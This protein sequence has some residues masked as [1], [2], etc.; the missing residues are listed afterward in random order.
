MRFRTLILL[1]LVAGFPHTAEA[2]VFGHKS[3]AALQRCLHGQLLDFTD[4]HGSDRRIWSAALCEKRDLYVYLPPCYD[5]DKH[6]PLLLWFHGI[7]EDEKGL[8]EQALADIDRA[9]RCGKLPPLIVAIPDGSLAGRP[10]RFSPHSGFLNTRAGA[11]EDYLLQD[12]YAFLRTNFPIRPEREAHILAGVSI[13]GGAAFHHAIKQRQE[14]GVVVGVFPP[15]NLRWLDCH[16]RYFGN[17]D[18]ACWGWRTNYRLGLEPVGKFAFGLVRVPWCRL[19]RPLYG[20]GPQVV[21]QMSRDN[22]IELLENQGL[23]DGELAMLVAYG[24][25]D[26]FNIDAQVESFLHRAGE[27]GIRVDWLRSP[28]GRHDVATARSF[29]P[30]IFD[31]LAPRLAPFA[32]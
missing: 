30:H 29:L 20:H 17:F 27:L 32:P 24:G 28:R 1:A 31:W 6:Y 26:Q 18:P 23:Q 22:P 2:R 13:G 16:G 14:F 8:P 11:F 25:K 7:D 5:A 12:V 19:V 15:L 21:G 9:I 3:L 4:N 10:G